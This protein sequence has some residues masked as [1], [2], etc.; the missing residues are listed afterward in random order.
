MANSKVEVKTWPKDGLSNSGKIKSSVFWGENPSSGWLWKS[1]TRTLTTKCKNREKSNFV[2]A[3]SFLFVVARAN[4]RSQS[5][6]S[7]KSD[8]PTGI[9]FDLPEEQGMLLSCWK[10]ELDILTLSVEIWQATSHCCNKNLITNFKITNGCYATGL[11][12][13]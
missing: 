10:F 6:K 4:T 13:H 5:P 2:K 12:N 8:H 3:A 1:W 11:A 7:C 9:F